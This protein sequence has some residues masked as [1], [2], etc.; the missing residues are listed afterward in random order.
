MNKLVVLSGIIC[1]AF[2]SVAMPTKNELKKVQGVVNELTSGDIQAMKSGRMDAA[3]VAANAEKYACEAETE[4]AKFLL[5][6]GSFGLYMQ[7]GSY[8]DALRVLNVLTTEVKDVPDKVLSEIVVAKLKKLSKRDGAA[9]FEYYERLERRMRLSEERGKVEKALKE[10]PQS[11]EANRDMAVCLAGLNDWKGALEHFV[12]TGGK[13]KEAAETELKGQ[14]S[15]AADLWWEAAPADGGECYREH[16]VTLYRAAMAD[17]KLTG[18]KLALAKKRIAEVSPSDDPVPAAPSAPVAPAVVAG[19]KPTP[20]PAAP[21]A[22]V[23]GMPKPIV[24]P[25]KGE[26]VSPIEFVP[27]PAGTAKVGEGEPRGLNAN[28]IVKITR[29][30]LM[31]KQ[32]ISIEQWRPVVGDG[33]RAEARIS[34][35]PDSLACYK[36]YGGAKKV[37]ALVMREDAD[38]FIDCLN[39]DF[40]QYLPAGMVFRHPTL[41]EIEY[42]EKGGRTCDFSKFERNICLKATKSAEYSWFRE[43]NLTL[44]EYLNGLRKAGVAIPEGEIGDDFRQMNAV[45][46]KWARNF[47][48]GYIRPLGLKKPNPYGICDLYY[49]ATLLDRFGGEKVP[50]DRDV[51]YRYF[52]KEFDRS[53]AGTQDPLFWT[54]GKPK[55]VLSRLTFHHMWANDGS[56]GAYI[57]VVIGPDLVSEWRARHQK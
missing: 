20:V 8:N 3:K 35:S 21:V 40:R 51:Q 54:E 33:A 5:L 38:R 44:P 14:R 30:F 19:E 45:F 18:L 17:G 37:A 43:E 24:I 47:S 49:G 23:R 29:P 53:T 15:A 2:V 9:V 25:L 22:V 56:M 48:T 34:R 4:A 27:I 28:A 46:G 16:A 50:D 10:N 41:A 6:K 13:E 7:G 57:R 55:A 52:F 26:G 12:R 31:A 32:L 11:K 39:R 1:L 42:V 36:A